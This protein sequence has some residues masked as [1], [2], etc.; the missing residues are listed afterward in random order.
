MDKSLNLFLAKVNKPYEKFKK[1]YT[2]DND[3]KSE[4]TGNIIKHI[5][6]INGLTFL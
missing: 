2:I 4:F 3:Y 1:M 5:L 6:S